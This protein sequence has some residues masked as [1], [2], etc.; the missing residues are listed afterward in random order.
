MR[1]NRAELHSLAGAYALDALTEPDHAR[2][3]RHLAG[4][5]QCRQ[6]VRGFREAAARVGASAAVRPRA[7]L[8]DQ[9]MWAASRTRQL[10]P[11]RSGEQPAGWGRHAAAHGRVR[12]G[13]VLAGR[14]RPGR[15]LTGR[16]LT[17]RLRGPWLSWS[18]WL[19]RGVTG[20][21]AVVVAVAV[22]MGVLAASAQHRLRQVQDSQNELAAVVDAPDVKLLTAAMTA[23][24]HAHVLESPRLRAFV[25]TAA[26]LPALP[27]AKAYE[28][29][30]IGPAGTRPAGLLPRSKAGQTG[31]VVVAGLAQG[32]HLGVT[33]EPAGG[34][35]S[36]TSRPVLTLRLLS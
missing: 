9:A 34:V 13:R 31:P 17:G 26:G 6:E 24:G 22:A 4:C 36:P 25:F 35:P 20:L 2:F 19:A 10:P 3:E 8:R 1:R 15:A 5:E 32:D 18:P 27:A 33:V 30:L 11:R 16:A 23:G 28:L 7:E 21:A 14:A 29:W 12:P